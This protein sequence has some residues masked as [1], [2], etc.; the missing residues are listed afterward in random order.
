MMI[1]NFCAPGAQK[2]LIIIKM[3]VSAAG[4]SKKSY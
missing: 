1:N 2:L 3:F 4:A